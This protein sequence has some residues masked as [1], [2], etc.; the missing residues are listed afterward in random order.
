LTVAGEV[1]GD[2]A[3]MVKWSAKYDLNLNCATVK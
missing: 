1:V 2:V 3:D